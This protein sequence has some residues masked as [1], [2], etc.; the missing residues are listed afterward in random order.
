[1]ND[2]KNEIAHLDEDSI[3]RILGNTKFDIKW[4]S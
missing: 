2:L 4:S 1:M 3:Q